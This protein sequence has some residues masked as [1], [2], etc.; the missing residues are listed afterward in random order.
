MA[1]LIQA[2]QRGIISASVAPLSQAWK[3]KNYGKIR[4]IYQRSSI[5]QLLFS[6]GMFALIWLNFTDG[7]LSFN[8]NKDYLFARNVFLFVGLMRIVDMGTGLNAQIISTSIYWRFEFI[9][10]LILLAITLPFN[11]ILTRQLG[12][13]GPAIANLVA[14]SIY[15]L[16]RYLFL[17][18]KLNMQPFTLKSLYSIFLAGGCY[19]ICYWLFNEGRGISWMVLRST[20]FL[21]LF[22]SGLIY[23]N[24]SP[25]VKP[26]LSTVRKRLRI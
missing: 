10:G 4:R 25:D 21:I 14:F 2:P 24:L 1:S 11:Y 7:I 20:I 26:V 8:L 5:N 6:T 23:F 17:L 9:T 22:I 13:T 15:N 3:D 19:F 16:I 12:L 18:R